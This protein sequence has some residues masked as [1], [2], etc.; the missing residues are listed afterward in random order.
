M[1]AYKCDRCGKFYIEQ[2]MSQ[3]YVCDVIT[4]V[5]DFCVECYNDLEEFMNVNGGDENAKKD[6]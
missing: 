2:T 5:L 1:T 3:H 4:G 6:I